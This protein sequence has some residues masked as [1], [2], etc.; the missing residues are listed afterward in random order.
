MN[1]KA[2]IP[3]IENNLKEEIQSLKTSQKSKIQE[4]E[5][6]V[7]VAENAKTQANFEKERELVKWNMEKLNYD[8]KINDL[9]DDNEKLSRDYSKVIKENENYKIERKK[10]TSQ[11]MARDR[12]Y[13]YARDIPTENKENTSHQ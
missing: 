6:K 12:T 8:S 4:L 1:V 5:E 11:I 7:K 10:N 3:L 2:Q 9:K 13:L